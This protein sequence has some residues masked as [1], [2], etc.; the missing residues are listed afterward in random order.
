MTGA[1]PPRAPESVR[2][3]GFDSAPAR[4]PAQDPGFDPVQD[5]EVD[6]A[7]NPEVDPAQNPAPTLVVSGYASIDYALQ[8]APFEGLDATTIVRSRAEEW[9]RFGGVAHV[10]RAAAAADPGVRVSAL[11]WVGTDTEATGW[12]NAIT[13]GGAGTAGVAVAGSRS[14]SSH[15][16]YPEGQGT[17]CLFD[18]GDCHEDRLTPNQRTLL[19]TADL[20]V[21]TIGPAAATAEL[22]ELLPAQCRL[23]WIVKQDPASLPAALADALAARATVVTLSDGERGYVDT[24]SQHSR[25]GTQI[26]LTRGSAGAELLRVEAGGEIVSCG[27]V[28]AEPVT[29]VDTTGA[30][31]TFSGTL[32]A[33][34]A[35]DPAPTTETMLDHI[36]H[37][38]AA[39]ARMLA[40]RQTPA[41]TQTK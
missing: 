1:T 22:L 21:V 36:R 10:T 40:A 3:P 33:R 8:L 11:S 26:V 30:G 35:R 31:D 16:L 20:A 4:V 6:P 37:A 9:P 15:L 17:I 25:T 39:T 23:F 29:G 27:S 7:Q 13:T 5:P 34:L 2:D 24:I 12:L 41:A 18:P 32:A 14:P 19:A 38:A 28:P